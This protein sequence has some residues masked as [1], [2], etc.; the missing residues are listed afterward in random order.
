M[1]TCRFFADGNCLYG[2]KC[3][4]SHTLPQQGSLHL[5]GADPTSTPQNSLPTMSNAYP[6]EDNPAYYYSQYPSDG[7][8]NPTADMNF[9]PSFTPNTSSGYEYSPKV[10][11]EHSMGVQSRWNSPNVA[12][13]S[14]GTTY[15]YPTD[16]TQNSD[17]QSRYMPSL[18]HAAPTPGQR[19]LKSF[20]AS[21]DVYQEF[22]KR[23]IETLAVLG[24]QDPRAVRLP[25]LVRRYH[26]L[27]P[28][29][30]S[31]KDKSVKLFGHI[32]HLFK[33]I[34]TNDRLPYLM[35]RI[36]GLYVTDEAVS[37]AVSAW[38][39][40]QHPTIITLHEAFNTTEF[41]DNSVVFLYDYYPCSVTVADEHFTRSRLPVDE[42]TIWSYLVQ[43]VSAL[44]SVHDAKLA[45]RVIH[46]SKVI[47]TGKN[48]IR[49]SGVGILDV[50]N[51]D[52]QEDPSEFQKED[53]IA[54]GRLLLC[55]CNR[56]A[57]ASENM[58]VSLAHLRDKYSTELCDIITSLI[59]MK[60]TTI[61]DINTPAFMK[62][63][64]KDNLHLYKFVTAITELSY[65]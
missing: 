47:L 20:F 37:T 14:G 12:V 19:S 63:V 8:R 48:R 30:K 58:D 31:D 7:Y 43:L 53:L 5:A 28:L 44:R 55:T 6:Q 27:Y 54:I 45:C 42:D 60:I 22:Y 36:D 11:R 3:K 29:D 41:N 49:I 2:N 9:S 56:K 25:T 40:V 34:H 52:K 38:K 21:E 24:Q 51:Y 17:K 64:F 35:R 62:H 18:P 10:N 65:T 61:D 32:S 4:Y 1:S 15:F 23:A 59:S 33:C 39:A 46:P 57:D 16:K 26:S 13:T 50:L